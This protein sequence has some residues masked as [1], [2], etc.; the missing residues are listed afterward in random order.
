MVKTIASGPENPHKGHYLPLM[1]CVVKPLSQPLSFSLQNA[2][3]RL[4]SL[5]EV[6]PYQAEQHDDEEYDMYSGP[7]GVR[8]LSVAVPSDVNTPVFAVMLN[9]GGQ[10]GDFLKL[11]FMLKRRNSS[12]AKEREKKVHTCISF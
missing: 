10:V 1:P 2:S 5:I 9:G 6:A 8:V 11:S 12:R 7:Q 4:H 3:R